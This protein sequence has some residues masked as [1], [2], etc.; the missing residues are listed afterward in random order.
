M[1]ISTASTA[2]P[3]AAPPP[4]DAWRMLTHERPQRS[5]AW[6]NDKKF[7]VEGVNVNAAPALMV[8]IDH[9]HSLCGVLNNV[10]LE[11]GQDR[12]LYT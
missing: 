12:F 5:N 3:R 2:M 7:E 10:V 4:V 6:Y 8:S 1:P 11:G 9:L